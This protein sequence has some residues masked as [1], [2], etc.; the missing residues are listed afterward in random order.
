MLVRIPISNSWLPF[1]HGKASICEGSNGA[2]EPVT[3]STGSEVAAVGGEAGEG[4][5]TLAVT[6]ETIGARQRGQ[7]T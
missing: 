5:G 7:L 1:S 4:A 6:G 3:C 2:R